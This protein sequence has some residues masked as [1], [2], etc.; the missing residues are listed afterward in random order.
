MTE[1]DEL[2][3]QVRLGDERAFGDWMGRVERPIHRMLRPFAPAVDTESV[4]QETLVR[5]WH[6]SQHPKRKLE[7]DNAS[8]RFAFGMAR[9]LARNLARKYRREHLLPT[10]DS[11]DDESPVV[12]DVRPDPFLR[13]II[14]KC[15]AALVG[16]LRRALGVRLEDGHRPAPELARSVRMTV[17]TFHQNVA[18]ARKSV[19]ECLRKHG[20]DE[21]E[22]LR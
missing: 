21:H 14:E 5:M 20:V 1:I 18:R 15:L 6:L 9:N 16:P 3:D 12:E 19:A 8:L 13:W 10:S 4:V 2:W 7:G 22:A 17:N 11:T